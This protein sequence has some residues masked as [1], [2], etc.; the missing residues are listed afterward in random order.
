MDVRL[1]HAAVPTSAATPKTS[2]PDQTARVHPNRPPI[3]NMTGSIGARSL[4]ANGRPR[5]VATFLLCDAPNLGITA[6]SAG[7]N[8]DAAVL[9]EVVAAVAL[10]GGGAVTFGVLGATA[11]VRVAGTALALLGVVDAGSRQGR[12]VKETGPGLGPQIRGLA[13]AGRREP[14]RQR[15]KRPKAAGDRSAGQGIHDTPSAR[16]G[17]GA[18]ALSETAF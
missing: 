2:A 10:G 4:A 18:L 6:R 12:G 11:A 15:G 3:T 14:C 13:R 1:P 5:A 16:P 7:L 9:R 17:L 8:P